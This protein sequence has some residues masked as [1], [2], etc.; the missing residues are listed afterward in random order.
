MPAPCSLVTVMVRTGRT[1]GAL[2]ASLLQPASSTAPVSKAA[3]VAIDN[4]RPRGNGR[5]SEKPVESECGYGK[6]NA[7]MTRS[8]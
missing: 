3:D 6:R 4:E 8:Q 2:G 7:G 1:S 5:V